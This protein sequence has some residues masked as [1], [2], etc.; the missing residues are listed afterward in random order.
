VRKNSAQAGFSLV[1]VLVTFSI[2]AMATMAL[3]LVEISNAQRTRDLRSR[4]IAFA[5]AQTFMERL[6]RMSYGA[7][8]PPAL[9]ADDYDRIFG[10]DQDIRDL[11]LTQ[12]ERKDNNADG[13]IDD[14]PIRFTLRGTEDRGQWEIYIDTDLNG[15]GTLGT[16]A[17][18]TTGGEGRLDLMRIEIR[19]NGRIV[20]RT[21]R[22]RTAQEQDE[23][24][25][26]G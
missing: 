9:T 1:E 13:V 7:P 5:R 20:M 15:D 3:G 16:N 6:L 19:H 8:N 12:L 18:A 21:L 23:A 11:S 4:D 14:Q 22:A 26:L 17:V 10:S 24:L 2:F 25:G